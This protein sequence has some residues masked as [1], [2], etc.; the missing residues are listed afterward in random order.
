[1]RRMM[2]IEASWPSNS[3]AAVTKRTLLAGL[4]SVSLFDAERSV[5]TVSGILGPRQTIG[6][7]FSAYD[8]YDAYF[9]LTLL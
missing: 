9:T 1:M 8:A 3:D 7:R 6:M 5:I 2:L 4:Y